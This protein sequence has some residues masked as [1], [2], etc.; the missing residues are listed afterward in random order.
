[1]KLSKK[2]KMILI[3]ENLVLYLKRKISQAK[4]ENF[5]LTIFKLSI[6]HIRK[7]MEEQEKKIEVVTIRHTK[8]FIVKNSLSPNN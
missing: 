3:K 4:K 2:E 7:Y 6:R 1:M 8:V 5:T